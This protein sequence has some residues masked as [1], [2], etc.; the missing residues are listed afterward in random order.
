M[1]DD[2]KKKKQ[3]SWRAIIAGMIVGALIPVPV[4]FYFEITHPNP[5]NVFYIFYSPVLM[6]FGGMAGLLIS[7]F[8]NSD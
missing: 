1:C 4:Y 3:I 6:V 8:S 2:G 7:A 5:Y